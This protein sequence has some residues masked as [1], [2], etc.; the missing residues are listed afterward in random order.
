MNDH[1]YAAFARFPRVRHAPSPSLDTLHKMGSGALAL[2]M[3][4]AKGAFNRAC[5][6]VRLAERAIFRRAQELEAMREGKPREVQTAIAALVAVTHSYQ[7]RASERRFARE[8]L[9]EA[10]AEARERMARRAPKPVTS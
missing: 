6:R 10:V 9:H 8:A 1:D 4:Q 2:R 5:E 7:L 3:N